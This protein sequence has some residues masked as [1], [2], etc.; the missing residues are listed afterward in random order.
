VEDVVRAGE[1][2]SGVYEAVAG[3][4]DLL[5]RY[6][7]HIVADYIVHMAL[8]PAVGLHAIAA[9]ARRGGGDSSGGNYSSSRRRRLDVVDVADGD[10][11]GNSSSV[12]EAC[13]SEVV[14][15][16][17]RDAYALFGVLAPGEVQ[18]VHRVVG[19]GPLG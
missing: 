17:Q 1:Q 9:A 18:H 4:G 11:D 19:Q 5:G 7:H 14:A 12:D 2:L 15:V 10:V 13:S 16:A 8:E 6:C 3:A